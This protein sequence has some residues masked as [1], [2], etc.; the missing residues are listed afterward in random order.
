[1]LAPGQRPAAAYGVAVM[2]MRAVEASDRAFLVEMARLA[3]TLEDRPLPRGDDPDVRALLPTASDGTV[4]AADDAGRPLRAAWWHTHT[5]PLARDADGRPLREMAMAVIEDARGR[6]VG[7]ALIETLASEA[8]R[9]FDALT[10]NVHLGNPAVRLY[11]RAGFRVAG[12]G[13]GWFGA[14]MGR[15][16]R[17]G[18]AIPP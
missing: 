9:R 13:R 15:S 1:M 11:M 16:V 5:P 2:R 17:S 7:A 14:A 18:K 12:K 6:G 10:L 3:C 4:I 8:A